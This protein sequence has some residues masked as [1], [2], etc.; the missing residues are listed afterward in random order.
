M[1]RYYVLEEG[2][3]KPSK[4]TDL[5]KITWCDVL[6]PTD[7]EVIEVA[8]KFNI[9]MD[10]LEDCLEETE[11]PRYN[12][13]YVLKNNSLLLQLIYSIE[14][15]QMNPPS[16]PV[17]VFITP[18]GKLITI[19]DP[20]P[21][22]FE[23]VVETLNRKQI[24]DVN[25]LTLEIIHFLF[26]YLDSTSQK[27]STHV[28][29]MQAEIMKSKNITG[30]RQPFQT[31]S[32]I[33][34]FNTTVLAN[35][36]AIKAFYFRNQATFEKNLILLE[37]FNDVQADIEQIY[38]FTSIIQSVLANSLDAYA[39]V[40]NFNLTQIMKVVGSISL[41]LMIP[42]IIA[43]Y[44][45]MNVGLPGGGSPESGTLGTFFL[46][47]TISFAISFLIWWI[48]RKNNWL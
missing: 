9:N 16:V 36:S 3:V 35:L 45:G 23:T 41:I 19:H 7:N 29:S 2:K 15:D 39:S 37:K 12:Y 44:Y 1:I 40:I 18:Q 28:K 46:I 48:F 38:S 17:G 26:S 47:I 11:R 14:I 13:D 6:Q 25:F 30:I 43:S 34:F 42:T 8:Q 4:A 5:A 10:D 20:M 22:G 21:K 24:P 32:Y 31:N 27:L 33:I